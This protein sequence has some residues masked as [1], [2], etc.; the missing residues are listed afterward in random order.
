M[1]T[2]GLIVQQQRYRPYDSCDSNTNVDIKLNFEYYVIL[3]LQSK[4]LHSK[5]SIFFRYR[6]L[7]GCIFK[8][9]YK[10]IIESFMIAKRGHKVIKVVF[11]KRPL[12]TFCPVLTYN[13]IPVKHRYV[14][15]RCQI[16]GLDNDTFVVQNTM[17]QS[18][19]NHTIPPTDDEIHAYDR[20]HYYEYSNFTDGI[21]RRKVKCSKWVYDTDTFHETF[22]SKVCAMYSNAFAHILYR[23]F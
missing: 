19:I 21:Q 23:L 18:I 10:L 8:D 17:H 4:I 9:E 7:I 20:C 1:I 3:R 15:F 22:T 16:P 11:E 2:S 5:Q 14:I 6:V 12:R 13:N